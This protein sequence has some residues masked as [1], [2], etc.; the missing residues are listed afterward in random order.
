LKVER[1]KPNSGSGSGKHGR[2]ASANGVIRYPPRRIR[3]SANRWSVMRALADRRHEKSYI[4]TN[5]T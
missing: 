2:F 3:P 1:R 4:K 5:G